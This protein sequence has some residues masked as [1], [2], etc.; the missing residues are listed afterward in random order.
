MK[1]IDYTNDSR[2]Q[3]CSEIH[4]IKCKVP[5]WFVGLLY[6][7]KDFISN[8]NEIKYALETGTYKG[9]TTEFFCELFEKV[10][11]IEKFPNQNFYGGNSLTSLYSNLEKK[12]ENLKINIGDSSTIVPKILETHS[13]ESFLVLFDAHNGPET[14]L[15]NELEILKNISNKKDHVI[16]ID[17]WWDFVS[18]HETIK[19]KIYE[20]NSNYY[21][22][23]SEFSKGIA[24]IY[25]KK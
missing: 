4:K 24:I 21:I 23:I 25:I 22:K 15:L 2:W 12:Y 16:I 3:R 18:F 6:E 8:I 20:I 1:Y 13:N 17:D 9:E 14:P 19:E 11:S 5:N 10:Y 7:E